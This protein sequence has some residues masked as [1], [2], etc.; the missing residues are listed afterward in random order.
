MAECVCL[1]NR[2][3]ARYRG[4]ESLLFRERKAAH[5]GGFSILERERAKSL[6][7]GRDFEVSR[8][9]AANRASRSRD[10]GDYD[11]TLLFRKQHLESSI[12]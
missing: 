3:A 4:F 6:A 1:E 2:S 9:Q 7:R 12:E 8:M 5:W 11:G 10:S